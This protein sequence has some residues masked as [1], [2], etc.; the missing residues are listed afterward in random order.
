MPGTVY[1]V[2]PIPP[3]PAHT[4][5]VEGGGLRIG[6]EYRHLDDAELEANY[7]GDAMVEIQAN[8]VGAVDD[9][10]LSLHVAS[11]AD[12]HE[13]L[14]FDCFESGPHYHY[15]EP[16]G[17]RQTIVDY[18]PAAMGEMLA[19][20]LAQLRTRLE[21][22]LR[23]A[24]GASVAESLDAKGVAALVDR[25]ETLAREATAASSARAARGALR[26]R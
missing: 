15:I 18:D 13:Y 11:A 20:A 16:S 3:D 24:G 1:T 8:V 12:G 6:V 14:R 19:W 17:E 10:G 2:A 21:P 4:T 9:R 26:G 23:Q 25:V 7:E 5:W 22:M